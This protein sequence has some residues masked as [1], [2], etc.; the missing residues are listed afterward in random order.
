MSDDATADRARAAR[1]FGQPVAPPGAG[2]LGL[3][4]RV[5]ANPRKVLLRHGEEGIHDADVVDAQGRVFW[6]HISTGGTFVS[7]GD[8]QYV[9]EREPT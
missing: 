1:L 2:T 4:L 6:A 3:R 5:V 8:F 7:P 9:N